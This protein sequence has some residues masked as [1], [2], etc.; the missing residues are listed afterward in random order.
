MESFVK[1]TKDRD[2]NQSERARLNDQHD[3]FIHAMNG[4]TILAPVDLTQTGLRILDSGTADGRWLLHISSTSPG[5]HTY[6]GTDIDDALYPS[7]AP[8]NMHFQNQSIREPFPTEWEGAFD[9]VHQR[10]V[11]AAAPPAT[12]LSVVERLAGLLKPGGWLQLVEV[13]TDS[14]ATNGPELKRFLGYAQQLSVLGGMGPNLAKQLAGTLRDAGLRN[15]E[16]RSIDVKYGAANEEE[17]L[18][19]K[20]IN[21]LCNAVPPLMQG[22]QMMM[23]DKYSQDE[24]SS[25]QA[26]LRKELEEAGGCTKLLVVWGQRSTI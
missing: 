3:V 2:D 26:R 23:P 14:A 9:L 19:K 11:M 21:S 12:P 17:D 5:H 18:K 16:E 24:A 20:S 13:D 15:V 8:A 1:H 22:V 10:L 4:N 6:I 7:P 25:F